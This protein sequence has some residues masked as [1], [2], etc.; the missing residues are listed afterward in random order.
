MTQTVIIGSGVAATALIETLVAADPGVSIVVFE[1]GERITTRDF[2][3]W[4][5]YVVSGA[6][7]YDGCR[8]ENYPQRDNPG[9]NASAGT[10]EVPLRGSR[11]FAYGGSSLHW[12][13]WSFRLKPEDFVLRS[14][15]G[16]GLDWPFSYAA[17]EPYYCRAEHHLAVS[18][19]STDRLLPRSQDFPFKA[20]PYTLED[21]IYADALDALSISYGKLP[22]A[23]RGV[24][25]EPSRHAPCQ[26]TGTCKYC[27]FGARYVASNY[28]DDLLEW[29]D[30]P[31]IEVRTGVAVLT[32]ETTGKRRASGVSY[33][34]RKSG[35]I[36][37]VAADRVIVAAGSIESAKLLLRSQST[38]WSNGIGNDTGQVGRYLI[39]HPY[40][41]MTAVLP[42]NLLGLQPE[43][44]FPTLVSRHFDSPAEQAKGK[45]MMVAPPDTV[46]ISLAQKMQAGNDRAAIDAQIKGANKI[47][48]QGMIE[49]F[50]RASN[51]VTNMQSVNKFGLPMTT[52]TYAQDPGFDA[53]MNEV[54]AQ[55][56]AIFAAMGATPD[57]SRSLSWRADHA[58][59]TCRMGD[60]ASEAV[61][62][63]D[64][65]VHGTDNIY[66]ISNAV[67]PNLGAVNPTLTLTALAIRL[68]DHLAQ[69]GGST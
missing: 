50:G 33:L 5:N 20:F 27:P 64:L 58:A 11:L 61:V 66:V 36:R 57:G 6:L 47:T 45:F 21:K 69:L 68:G 67:L 23:R 2:G 3:L 22:I 19:D 10:T 13:G 7:P 53:R 42:N 46:S 35:E 55:T 65:K 15:T 30:L 59:S 41:I 9:E 54:E 8:D 52:V 24:S 60:N 44:N 17:F 37:S 63:A 28:L 12:G 1:A 49:V 14:N 34:D 32:I 62:D 51:T 31:N 38:D 43:L 40:F 56:A 18:G 25:S 48:I 29:N 4:E 39:T 26:T 16:E